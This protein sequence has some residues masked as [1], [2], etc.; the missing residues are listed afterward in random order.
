MALAVDALT[1]DA[2]DPAALARFW[3]GVLGWPAVDDDRGGHALGPT[4]DTGFRVRFVASE[5]PKLVANQMH[6]DLTSTSSDDQQSTVERALALGGA[7]LDVGQR[8]EEGH[9]VLA[10]PEGN[11]LCVIPPG[12]RFLAGCPFVGCL[13]SDG[14]PA[15]GR[16]WS[17]ALDWPLVWDQD[18]ETAIQAPDGGPKISW[19]GPPYDPRAE[20]NRLHLDLVPTGGS[21]QHTEVGRLLDLGATRADVGQGDVPWVVLADPDGNQLCVLPTG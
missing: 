4:D 11:E 9:V 19:G 7:H 16:F 10:D 21:S 14:S 6:L 18:E 15:V 12:N 17:A 1:F 2:H 13:A 20:K 5:R 3:G 8:P